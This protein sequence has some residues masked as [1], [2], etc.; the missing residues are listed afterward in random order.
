L[1]SSIKG[2]NYKSLQPGDP[3]IHFNI[4]QFQFLAS[5]ACVVSF[6]VGSTRFNLNLFLGQEVDLVPRLRRHETLLPLP[7]SSS[8]RGA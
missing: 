5:P 7:R 6:L 2:V 1:L 3:K 4:I 8:W